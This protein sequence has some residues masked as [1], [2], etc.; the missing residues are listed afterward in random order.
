VE[1]FVAWF[2]RTSLVWLGIGVLLGIAMAFHPGGTLGYVPAHVHANLLGF[3]S[4]MIFGVAYHAI[5]R[6]AGRPLHQRRLAGIHFWL[7]NAGLALLFAGFVGRLANPGAMRLV[8]AGSLVSALG[9]SLFIYNLWRTLG[10]VRAAAPNPLAR[11][12]Q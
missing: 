2:V 7:A 6:F 1:W 5:P 3:V 9:V 4:M 12:M 10:P 8:E 11:R